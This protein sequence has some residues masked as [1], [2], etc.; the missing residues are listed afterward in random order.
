MKIHFIISTLKGGGAERVL[1]LLATDLAKKGFEATAITLNKG[2]EYDL[3]EN[4]SRIS[5]SG[6]NIPNHTLRSFVNLYKLYRNK[7]NRPDVIISFITLTNLITIPIAKLF[8]IKIIAAEHNSHLRI[9]ENRKMLSDFTRKVLYK[10]AD[11]VTVLTDYDIPYYEKFGVNA[12]VM[13]NPCTFIPIENNDG[14]REKTIIA[15]GSLDRY[16]HKGFDN[17]IS[18][19][20][21]VLKSNPDWILKIVGGGDE[22]HKYLSTLVAEHQMEKQIIFTGFTTKVSEIMRASSI[23]IL[24]SRFEGLPM[25]LLE[26]MSQGMACIS[27]DC[28]TGPSDIITDKV[29]GILIEDQ[30]REKMTMGLQELIDDEGLRKS[31]S[32]RAIKSLDRYDIDKITDDYISIFKTITKEQ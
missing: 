8:S 18:F 21:P 6:G 10:K 11:L 30:D 23:F 25:V 32:A 26:A 20:A 14:I 31:L 7:K 13:P 5:L 29:N 28:K 15:V 24:P 19:I 1:A 12:M 9:M 4:V 22:G 2:D 16:H 17:L 3:N 27:Y